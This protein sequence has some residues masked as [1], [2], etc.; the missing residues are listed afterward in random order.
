[1]YLGLG[2]RVHLGLGFRVGIVEN[3]IETTGVTGII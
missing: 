3:K 2:F 1:M